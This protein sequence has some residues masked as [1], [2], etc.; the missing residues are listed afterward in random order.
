M[1][2]K[3]NPCF[4]IELSALTDVRRNSL[5]GSKRF[6]C[7]KR[8]TWKTSSKLSPFFFHDRSIDR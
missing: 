1:E 8:K 6:K 2:L 3:L 7:S 4:D 5:V